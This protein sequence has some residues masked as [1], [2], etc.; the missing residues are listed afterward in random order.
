[1]DYKVLLSYDSRK[2]WHKNKCMVCTGSHA[3]TDNLRWG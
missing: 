2:W 3:C 1:L